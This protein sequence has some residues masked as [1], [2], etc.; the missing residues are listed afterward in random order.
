MTGPLALARLVTVPIVP[1]T[2]TGGSL[3]LSEITGIVV[4]SRYVD[5]VDNDG[6][7]LIPPTL[8]EFAETFQGDLKEVLGLD[9]QLTKG[10]ERT[11]NTIFVTIGN[12]T[13]FRDAAGRFTSEAYEL[14]VDDN[15]VVVTG[16]SPLGAW[17]ATRSIIQVASTGHSALPK[18]SGVDAPGWG[19]RGVM[20]NLISHAIVS[21]LIITSSTLVGTS[22]PQIS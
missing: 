10:T 8:H 6:P 19:T 18:G 4:D 2:E 21:L 3:K 11:K 17:W 12:D 7:T 16:A 5:S 22:T 9:L 13:G 14:K 20:V 1:F 15:G